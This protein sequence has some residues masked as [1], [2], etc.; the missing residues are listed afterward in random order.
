MTGR[1]TDASL[2]R[3]GKALAV[4]PPGDRRR[5]SDGRNAWRKMTPAQRRV[6]LDWIK[7]EGLE[8]AAGGAS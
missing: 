4:V 3:E 7:G 6:F 8:V 1:S 2:K 5:M